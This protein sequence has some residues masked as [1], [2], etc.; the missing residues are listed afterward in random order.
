[1]PDLV[2]GQDQPLVLGDLA[3]IDVETPKLWGQIRHKAPTGI[4]TGAVAAEV[5][6][7]DDRTRFRVQETSGKIDY[8]SSLQFCKFI[9][10]LRATGRFDF[11]RGT[12]SRRRARIKA[13]EQA[14]EESL[15]ARNRPGR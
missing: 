5:F 15:K 9:L 13:A 14:H 6:M 1:M 3:A 4:N 2:P 7:S 12:P 8:L 10:E 11:E